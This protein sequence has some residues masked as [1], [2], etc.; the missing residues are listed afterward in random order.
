MTDRNKIASEIQGALFSQQKMIKQAQDKTARDQEKLAAIEGENHILREVLDL[1]TKG[2]IDPS[3]ALKTAEQ[4]LADPGRMEV[5]KEA[6]ALGMN[7][8]LVLGEVSKD[9][10]EADDKADPLTRF[11][12]DNVAPNTRSM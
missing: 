11:L 6:L 5:L 2:H 10:G 8:S 7:R 12:R 9:Q 1:V 4:F 3:D